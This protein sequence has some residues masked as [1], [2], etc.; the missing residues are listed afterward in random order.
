MFKCQH[1]EVGRSVINLLGG[2]SGGH[3]VTALVI[4]LSTAG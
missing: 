1:H 4:A 2:V 3:K